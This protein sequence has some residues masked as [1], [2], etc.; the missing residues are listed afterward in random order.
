MQ[1]THCMKVSILL[2]LLSVHVTMQCSVLVRL[3]N[4]ALTTAFYWSYLSCSFLCSHWLLWGWLRLGL[5]TRRLAAD[6]ALLQTKYLA[7]QFGLP[8]MT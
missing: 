6:I 2:M 8:R 5:L 3:N 1:C 7:P 4:F